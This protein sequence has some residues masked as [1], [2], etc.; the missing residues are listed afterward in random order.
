MDFMG[1]LSLIYSRGVT[2]TITIRAAGTSAPVQSEHEE[3]VQHEAWCD[4]GWKSSYDSPDAADRGLR[5]HQTRHC[6]LHA[7]QYEWLR[8]QTGGDVLDND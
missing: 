2:I 3:P 1:F 7:Q 6:V 5:T 8:K 4:C